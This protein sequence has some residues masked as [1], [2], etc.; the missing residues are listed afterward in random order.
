MNEKQPV[1]YEYIK[2]LRTPEER[3][4]HTIE[5]L[6]EDAQMLGD[7]S[8]GSAQEASV[9]SDAFT[10]KA[11]EQ[12]AAIDEIRQ[13]ELFVGGEGVMIPNIKTDDIDDEKLGISVYVDKDQP[14]RS[15]EPYE[16]ERGILEGVWC[17]AVTLSDKTIRVSPNLIM[18]LRTSP[19][20]SFNINEAQS[21]FDVTATR[22]A[23]VSLGSNTEINVVVLEEIRQRRQIENELALHGMANSVFIK[24]LNR[25]KQVMRSDAGEKYVQMDKVKILRKLGHLAEVQAKRGVSHS[26]VV[27]STLLD[28]IGKDREVKI[29]YVDQVEDGISLQAE[30]K[31]SV[32]DVL[33][34]DSEQDLLRSTIVVSGQDSDTPTLVPIE[35]IRSFH[36]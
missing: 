15:L 2:D 30:S 29:E 14:I 9:A 3:L 17:T 32:L 1:S 16:Q 10:Q 28:A 20:K 8:F 21:L 12:I 22:H 4:E 11:L 7:V 34:P 26:T 19:S 23:I 18:G 27:A 13:I 33:M 31:G 35:D 36:F 6:K 5:N 25:L 24:Q